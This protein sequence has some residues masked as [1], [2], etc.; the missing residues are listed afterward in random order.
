MKEKDL[1]NIN[2]TGVSGIRTGPGIGPEVRFFQ[3][4]TQ[5]YLALTLGKE[6]E[7]LKN[8]S[9]YYSSLNPRG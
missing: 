8:K 1:V 7:L 3:K 6:G 5:V 2:V 9:K 4:E